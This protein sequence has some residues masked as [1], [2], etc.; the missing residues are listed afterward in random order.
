MT[1]YTFDLD[2]IAEHQALYRA[3]SRTFELAQEKINNRELIWGAVTG[4]L[5]PRAVDRGI[6]DLVDWS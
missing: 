3:F 2:E 1:T 4:V 5:L 6:R